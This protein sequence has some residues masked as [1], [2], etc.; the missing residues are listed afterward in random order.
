M[1][2]T[3]ISNNVNV[4]EVTDRREKSPSDA[5]SPAPTV[6]DAAAA[7]QVSLTLEARAINQITDV[8]KGEPEVDVAKVEAI[9]AELASGEFQIDSRSIAEGLIRSDAELQN[10]Q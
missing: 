4:A 3:P 5:A 6:N 8:A 1:M 9:R 2:T 7:D 10:E